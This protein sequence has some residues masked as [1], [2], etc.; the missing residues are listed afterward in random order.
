MPTIIDL[1]CLIFGNDSKNLF[2]VKIEATKT[3]AALKVAIKEE[4]KPH[5]DNIKAEKLELFKVSIPFDPCFNE[6]V[7]NL[8][9]HDAVSLSGWMKLSSQFSD[10]FAV[11]VAEDCLH[12]VVRVPIDPSA[13]V[14]LNCYVHC[15]YPFDP[16][17]I[18]GVQIPY[19]QTV[20]DLMKAIKLEML[21][22]FQYTEACTLKLWEVSLLVEDDCQEN[23]DMPNGNLLLPAKKLLEVFSDPPDPQC[24]HIIAKVVAVGNC[25]QLTPTSQNFSPVHFFQTDSLAQ[26]SRGATPTAAEDMTTLRTKFLHESRPMAPSTA[27][28]PNGFSKRQENLDQMIYCNR[29]RDA[30][31]P[32]PVTLLHPIFGQFIDDC[33]KYKPMEKDN[34]FVLELLTVMSKFY[35]DEA[36][37]AD[38]VRQ[39]F[40]EKYDID[41]VQ[42]VIE[43]IAYSTD[44]D[45]GRTN[46][47]NLRFAIIDFKNDVGSKGAEPLLQSIHY[48]L[49]SNR[50]RAPEMPSSVLP[51]MIIMIFGAAWM[52]R[53]VSQVLSSIIP[54]YFD[55]SDTRL[56]AMAA[57]HLGAFKK[58]IRSLQDYYHNDLSVTNPPVPLSNPTSIPSDIFPYRKHFTSLVDSSEHHFE[59]VKQ[60]EHHRLFFF[61]KLSDGRGICIKF[62]HD[63]SPAVHSLCASKGFALK[64]LGFEELPG[65]WWM[66]VM[67]HIDENYVQFHDL[68]SHHRSSVLEYLKQFLTFLHAN[69][70]VHGD[71]RD[72]NIMVP[73]S[74]ELHFF[75]I[76]FDWAGRIGEVRY[77]MNVNRKGIWRPD[78]ARDGDL[79]T[80]EHDDEMLQHLH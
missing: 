14:R 56:R 80:A 18:V 38:S 22:N 12:V 4:R 24:I 16:S 31:A 8:D 71:V 75:L 35:P 5:F 43:G 42:T 53:P 3:V 21:E 17:R 63:Y 9:L 7:N 67:E 78:G 77:P 62:T 60:H 72:T 19:G 10:Q 66:V 23:F 73:R 54:F 25:K 29:P 55:F 68:E 65:G 79:I 26:L 48:Y 2:P 40:T 37:R 15:S 39:L 59:Y 46:C 34:A 47:R 1:F 52:D 50:R 74:G 49:E 33:E 11:N 58:A 36:E 51:C 64:L 28:E 32:I 30:F 61:G 76:D 13:L 27:G 6:K 69:G 41:F 20:K 70:F 44:G 45:I 57:R